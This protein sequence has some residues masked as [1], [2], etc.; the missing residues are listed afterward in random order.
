MD[1]PV[2]C[3]GK[4]LG[5]VQ[6][7]YKRGATS[8]DS[9]RNPKLDPLPGS[10]PEKPPEEWVSGDEPVTGAQ[11]SYLTTLCEEAKIEAPLGPLTKAEASKLID[12]LKARLGR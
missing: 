5:R 3:N 1:R 7:G 9:R 2:R 11:A 8:D 4:A 10:N 6:I 12:E